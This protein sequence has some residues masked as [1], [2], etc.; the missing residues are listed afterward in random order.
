MLDETV[1]SAPTFSGE[2]VARSL[3]QDWNGLRDT[4]EEA[5]CP[6]ARTSAAVGVAGL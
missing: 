6:L 2:T 3:A 5:P 4:T 1:V